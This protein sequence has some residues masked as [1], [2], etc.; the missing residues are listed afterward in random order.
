MTI[1]LA[2]SRCN[3]TSFSSYFVN[4]DGNIVPTYKAKQCHNPKDHSL[5]TH[6]YK[7]L[8]TFQYAKPLYFIDISRYV[9]AKTLMSFKKDDAEQ[10]FE[11]Y[12]NTLPPY[13]NIT[14]TAIVIMHIG[15][16]VKYIP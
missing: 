10:G 15:K 11:S 14:L 4:E 6:H 5:N 12:P 7:K 2:T 13:M 16:S 1:F 9:I 3:L 8:K